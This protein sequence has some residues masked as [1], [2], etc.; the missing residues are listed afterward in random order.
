M[1][2]SLGGLATSLAVEKMKPS[3]RPPIVL[4]APAVNTERAL[5]NFF[6]FLPLGKQ[7]RHEMEVFIEQIG[8]QPVSYYATDRAV[9]SLS[10]PVLWIHDEQ[11]DIC[12]FEDVQKIYQASP[13]HVQFLITQGF[14]H[15]RIYR[16]SKIKKEIVTFLKE[17]NS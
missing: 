4:I 8:Q 14:G 12:P 15:S 17:K 7:I 10:Q 13:E 3:E 16:E 11:D 6:T 9:L 1:A 5:D 2:H